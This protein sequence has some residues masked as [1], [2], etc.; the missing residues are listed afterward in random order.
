[1]YYDFR[2]VG[3]KSRSGGRGKD[4]FTGSLTLRFRDPNP[5]LISCDEPVTRLTCPTKEKDLEV[6]KGTS[7]SLK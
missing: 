3:V 2:W 7:S 1:M 4:G 6:K 5:N